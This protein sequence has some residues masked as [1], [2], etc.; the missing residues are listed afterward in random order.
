MKVKFIVPGDPKGIGRHC[1]TKS[2]H[3]YTP[4]QTTNYENLVKV[5]YYQHCRNFKFDNDAQLDVRIVAYFP[6]PKSKSKKM[7]EAMRTHKVRPIVK[8]DW[9]NI[10]KIICDALNGIAY[11][12]DKQVV[13]AQVRKFYSDQPRV[14]VTIQEAQEVIA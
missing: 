14:I 10:G 11:H 4:E 3:T 9:D 6:I 7:Q 1:T 13:D 8:C 12:D 5:M 2:G